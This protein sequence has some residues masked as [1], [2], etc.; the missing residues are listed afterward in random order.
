MAPQISL[1][2]LGQ[3][4]NYRR[5]NDLLWFLTMNLTKTSPDL[6]SRGLPIRFHHEGDPGER[7][8]GGRDP[9]EYAEQ[10]RQEILGELAGM[11]IVWN[12]HGRPPGTKR[13]RL[14]HW[15]MVIGGILDANGLVEF[16]D[17]VGEA[18]SEFNT[19]LE[20]LAALAEAA[21]R[22]TR[23]GF[24]RVVTAP[25]EGGA[26]DTSAAREEGGPIGHPANAWE[27]VF[28]SADVLTDEL[29]NAKSQRGKATRIG[30]F[31]GQHQGRDVPIEQDGNSGTAQLRI[32][33]G[34]ARQ[35]L[36]F[37]EIRGDAACGTQAVPRG[38]ELSD[39]LG[40]PTTNPPAD[41]IRES[42]GE[43]NTP[44]SHTDRPEDGN[45]EDWG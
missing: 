10:H 7:E 36:Y 34:R 41:E 15:A 11:V 9:L 18:A 6:V 1:R 26:L 22:E 35:K 33:S 12:Q 42:Q 25:P 40:P 32:I 13:H 24:V 21:L 31:L 37:F 23:D 39:G 19:A 43:H 30:S 5:P 2:I 45:Q 38:V 3:S 29:A 16:L 20:T 8:F 27:T 17:N 44:T 4:A 14:S 28:R